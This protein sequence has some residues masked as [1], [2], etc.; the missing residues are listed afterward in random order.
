M[1]ILRKS[2]RAGRGRWARSLGWLVAVGTLLLAG[3]SQAGTLHVEIEIG[4]TLIGPAE[5]GNSVAARFFAVADGRVSFEVRPRYAA[6]LE[7]LVRLL[8]ES[9]NEIASATSPPSWN[10]RDDDD[11]NDW[12][13]GKKK[14]K[15]NKKDK[16]GWKHE[17]HSSTVRL[18]AEIPA[19]GDYTLEIESLE[20][21]GSFEARTDGSFPS[22]YF[23]EG[24]V[25]DQPAVYFDV[26]P[27]ARL[28]LTAQASRHSSLRPRIESV[29][30]SAGEI[31]IDS[32]PWWDDDDGW[33]S[34]RWWWK[35][36]N[37]KGKGKY[38]NK[39]KGHYSDSV[40]GIVAEGG[41]TVEVVVGGK[42]S[43]AFTLRAQVDTRLSRNTI[44]V[45]DQPFGSTIAGIVTNQL[46]GEP[47]AGV[48]VILE[49]P[50]PGSELVTGA[51]GSYSTQVEPGVY[52]VSFVDRRFEPLSQ[53]AV[54]EAGED[55]TVDAVL[56][57]IAP[58]LV[59]I[60]IGGDA[61]PE[62][63]LVAVAKIDIL[64]GSSLA[65]VTWS[66]GNSVE[67]EIGDP[68]SP[69]TAVKLPDASAYKAE[70]F[71][72]LSEPPIGEEDLPPGV[73]LP[74]GEFP[75]GL[76]NR[77]QVVG[78]NPFALEET[79]LV[80]LEV[81]VVTGSG[82]YSD[83]SEI[84]TR[85]PWKPANAIRN[86][87]LGIP[88]LLHGR[89]HVDED[90][91]GIN[92]DTGFP[93]TY[94]WS[95]TGPSNSEATLTD[96]DQQNPEFVPDV[97]GRYTLQI[98]DTTRLP[99]NEDVVIE[100]WA[101]TWEGV[102]TGQDA[103]GLPE[104]ENCT[105]CHNDV[106]A[107]DNFTPWSGTGHAEIFST[108]LDTNPRYS[109]SC[110]SCHTVGFDPE[111]DNGGIDD[112]PD[113]ADFLASGLLGSP[114][115]NWT[116]MLEEFPES[117]QLANAQCENC[118][119]PQNGGAH[120]RN[121]PRATLAADGC[122]TCHGEPLRHARFQQWQLSGHANYELAIEEGESGNCSRCHTANGFLTW[123]PIL[124]DDD[125]NTDPL[126]N[127]EVTWTADEVHPQTCA[128]CHDPHSTG[129]T[130][131][132][133]NDATVRISGDT[134]PLIAG[135]TATDVGR[136]AIC[137]TC[138]N[139]RRGLRNDDTFPTFTGSEVSRAPHP[140][141][142]AD[143]I[144]GQNAYLVDVGNRGRHSL[145]EDTCAT[146]HMEET[147]PPEDLSYNQSGTN[148]TFYAS[149]EICS[150]C[151][152]FGA[153]VIQGPV[154][155]QL[156]ELQTRLEDAILALIEE[157][158]A[159]GNKID[160][161]GQAI[162]SAANV[163]EVEEIVFGE[164]RGQQAIEVT[165]A[166][167]TGGPFA[168]ST[169]RVLDANDERIGVLYDFADERL[170]KSGWNWGLVHNDSSHGV[171]NPSFAFQVLGASLSALGELA[172]P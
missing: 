42:G 114:G 136:G 7:L 22:H 122:A 63:E 117:A 70:L 26:M 46:T 125:P 168:M 152:G 147:P 104:A 159:L 164:A 47:V 131:G 33:W 37:G 71:H 110:F 120:A 53:E 58:V 141:P 151:H 49:P 20:G 21:M 88:V 10:D 6:E 48:T 87:G 69:V 156:D 59:S 113:W 162:I 78:I 73:E 62:A 140:G 145:L 128:T 14:N 74:P 150:E 155:A 96:P 35:W 15:K 75:G 158:T 51:D 66:Q 105:V 38:K 143:M 106:I 5:P 126:D 52:Q 28:D 115:D 8:D 139:S 108:L 4:D 134:P 166:G 77:W 91:D 153:E 133:D 61:V 167:Q 24:S 154:E 3:A 123:L 32:D 90:G 135:F 23:R 13:H 124:E 11:R 81:S 41:G 148:H 171:H 112:A 130:S 111:V 65:S 79:G 161:N 107:E 86:V 80:E 36:W 85:L 172:G 83:A 99:G 89:D 30:D 55:E 1:Q 72:V 169:V 16:H 93:T 138:H 94:S 149:P 98:T 18:S 34:G 144:M 67:V 142:Q 39:H 101:G 127:I 17:G 57:P 44:D 19:T 9:G 160:L 129:T 76:Q 92:D 25:P 132:D 31:P 82:E 40:K 119:G 170:I 84:H 29:S 64:D 103:N 100:I 118:H 95:L 116:T 157:Q 102:I 56:T 27:G 45:S 68:S 43:G 137:M 146:C 163:G 54:V 2:T 12:K 109:A 121:A 165:L 97:D 60:E 50:V